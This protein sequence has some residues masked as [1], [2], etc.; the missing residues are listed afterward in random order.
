MAEKFEIQME[1]ERFIH[2]DLESCASGLRDAMHKKIDS[3]DRTGLYFEMMGSLVFSAFAIEAKVNFVGWKHL[4]NGWPERANL[5]EKINLLIE[6]L[7]LDLSWEKRP[8]QTVSHLKS[9]R[10]T[11]AHGKP[12]IINKQETTDV[13]PTVEEML[14]GQWEALVNPE[15]VDRCCED[16]DELW[17]TLLEA[18]VIPVEDTLTHGNLSLKT[19]T[20]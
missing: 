12:D 4:G 19:I 8:L 7:P 14:R 11:I 18:A 9:F 2:N 6:V 13:K 10:D 5:R 3:D 16:I 17:K 15:N 1:A 20:E